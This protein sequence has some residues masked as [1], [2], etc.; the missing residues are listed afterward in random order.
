MSKGILNKTIFTD[1][2]HEQLKAKGMDAPAEEKMK[3]MVEAL[4]V[5]GSL[6]IFTLACPSPANECTG[7]SMYSD[8]K[9]IAKGLSVNERAI[10]FAR[11]CNF[12]DQCFRGDVF[13]GRIHDDEIADIFERVDFCLS[14][15]SSDAPWVR[16]LPSAPSR[17]SSA[18][19][20]QAML[21]GGGGGSGGVAGEPSAMEAMAGRQSAH[22]EAQAV[23]EAVGQCDKYV[24]HRES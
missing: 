8:D 4:S 24:H 23:L 21:K 22:E 16:R 15:L 5:S 7:V 9:A 19:A 17:A 13:I 12:P 3:S 11:V 10:G 14:D 20:M 18:S 2:V 1:S 6:D